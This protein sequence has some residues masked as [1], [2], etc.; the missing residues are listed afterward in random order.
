MRINRLNFKQNGALVFPMLFVKSLTPVEIETLENLH[1]NHPRHMPRLRAQ[2]ILLSHRGYSISA[3]Q[4]ICN[5]CRQTIATWLHRWESRGICGL[6]DSPRSGRPPKLTKTEETITLEFIHQS[7]RSLKS[8]IG[9][10]AQTL[11]ITLTVS[12]LK[13]L[14]K[15]AGLSWKRIRKSLKSKRDPALFEHSRKQLESL[16]EQAKRDQIDLFYFDESGFTLEPCVPYAWQAIGETIELSTSKSKRLNVLGFVNRDGQ[17]DS[18]VVEG[19]VNSAV[20]VACIDRFV[21]TLHKPTVLIIDNAPTHTSQEFNENIERWEQRGLTIQP[22]APYSPELNIIEI[23]WRKIKYEWLP[24]SAYES[25][26]K[27]KKELFNVLAC[28]GTE[29]KIEFA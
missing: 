24:F 21:E 23:V 5:Y 4:P 6:F 9:E 17:F 14:C 20:V 27:L 7:P 2:V 1:K 19:S 28:I 18:I 13:T 25:Y 22:I 15:R 29:Y 10:I 11:G 8:V 26:E 16:I 3:I 12:T